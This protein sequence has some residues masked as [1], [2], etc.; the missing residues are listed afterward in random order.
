MDFKKNMGEN[1]IRGIRARFMGHVV[2]AVKGGGVPGV[3]TLNHRQLSVLHP[4]QLDSHATAMPVQAVFS[5][6]TQHFRGVFRG[7]HW[8]TC[9]PP[10]FLWTNVPPPDFVKRRG[11]GGKNGEK[12]GKLTKMLLFIST[13]GTL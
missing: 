9:P 3:N 4:S 2:P 11:Q 1:R 12:R 6:V 13:F 7:G 8:R 10:R 5:M